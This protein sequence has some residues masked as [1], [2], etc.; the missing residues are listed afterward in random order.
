MINATIIDDQ[1]QKHPPYAQAYR[2]A[3]SERIN[4]FGGLDPYNP[5]NILKHAKALNFTQNRA[6]LA[7]TL[8]TFSHTLGASTPTLENCKALGEKNTFAIVCGH[9]PVL[10][11]GQM[12][13]LFKIATVMRVC[14][15][16]NSLQSEMR[17]VPVFWNASE[18]HNLAEF[19]CAS[20]F[21]NN[22]DLAS[23]R[24][25]LPE[26]KQRISAQHC[27]T[28]NIDAL[29]RDIANVLPTTEF[30][31]AL[32][33][34]LKNAAQQSSDI[35]QMF[36]R[37]L[38]KWFEGLIVVEPRT[39]RKLSN[40]RSVIAKALLEHE[41]VAN[42]F[43]QDSTQMQNLGFKPQLPP[44]DEGATLVFHQKAGGSRERISANNGEYRAIGATITQKEIADAIQEQPQQFSPSAA[45]RPVVQCATLP[46]VLYA[47]GGGELS[48]HFQL[49]SI[50]GHFNQTMPLLLPRSSATVIKTSIC[51]QLE[52]FRIAP[53]KILCK[54]ALSWENIQAKLESEDNL[55]GEAFEGLR[56]DLSTAGDSFEQKLSAAGISNHNE[57][58]REL[59]RF[60]AR[61]EGL[62]K[63]YGAQ[64]PLTGSKGKKQFFMLRKFLL[65]AEGYQDIHCWMIYFRA[66]FGPEFFSEAISAI[67]PFTKD[68]HLLYAR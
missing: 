58:S 56:N 66:L 65:P 35:G 7:Q 8:H 44:L 46:T 54:D 31:P 60:T 22:H 4:D 51:K 52:K 67:D 59:E 47:A 6:E 28:E 11:G 1:L 42:L 48:Y 57:W 27:D 37:L 36:S 30:T 53:E 19:C 29:I 24:L 16:L 21:D 12:F 32:I 43:A 2:S 39:L 20:V 50:F 13:I 40:Y 17:F 62:H 14:A 55:L 49:R 41:A 45:L 34:E 26:S 5:Q 18:D 68:H 3:G 25:S 38:L 15:E 64:N 10:F 23:F 33:S 9:Q 63:R 61:L